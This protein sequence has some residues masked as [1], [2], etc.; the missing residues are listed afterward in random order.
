MGPLI[1]WSSASF[2]RNHMY[3]SESSAFYSSDAD[4]D[5][6]LEL[7]TYLHQNPQRFSGTTRRC[8]PVYTLLVTC[9]YLRYTVSKTFSVIGIL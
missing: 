1:G 8:P 4:F 7:W 2:R 5:R 6:Y 9:I 3:I